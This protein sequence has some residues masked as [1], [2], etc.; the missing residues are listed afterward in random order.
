MSYIQPTILVLFGVSGN[1]AKNKLLPALSAMAKAEA[2]PSHFKIIGISRQPLTV[3]A[4]TEDSFLRQVLTLYQMDPGDLA[5]YTGLQEYLEQQTQEFPAS[6]QRVVY[7]S[8]PPN[9]VEGVIEGLGQTGIIRS[10]DKLLLEKPFGTDVA[11]AKTLLAQL[12]RYFQES[13]LY[14]IDHYMAK[15]M[16]QNIVTFR[17]SNALF[18]RTWN[19][20][21]IESITV[22]AS[23]VIDIEGRAEF[24][25]QTGAL[26][27]VMQNHLVQLAALVLMEL[28]AEDDWAT[29]PG[30]R[31][32]AIRQLQLATDTKSV[33]AQ[34]EGYRTAVDNPDSIV[35]TFAGVTLQSTD[36][37]WRG[38]PI[39][40]L[41]GKALDRKATEITIRYHKDAAY[42]AN[43]LTL[44]LQPNEGVEMTLWAKEP[45]YERHPHQVLLSFLYQHHFD[46]LPEAYE[47]VLVDVMRA[48]HSLFTTGEEVLASWK[49]LQ[50]LQ[51]LWQ[52]QA[53]I[54][55]Y[56]PGTSSEIILQNY[57]GHK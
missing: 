28:P 4:I 38:V 6:G 53:D 43:E 27:D 47:R 25:E 24:Y 14:R 21:F 39:H 22:L 11:S 23:E 56:T 37:A 44:R 54:P 50:P 29:I 20:T 32:Q 49:L 45:G 46:G 12:H 17:S 33:R 48:D 8:L 3:E 40:L 16:A 7:A 15:E 36:P 2:L 5:A 18:K 13:Q 26:R 30:K 55:S 31:L 57:E 1:L 34:Y 42:E 51:E 35:E 9:A 19:S 52:A 10:N 41:T